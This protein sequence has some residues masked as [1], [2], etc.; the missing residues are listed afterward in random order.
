MLNAFRVARLSWRSKRTF[1]NSRVE[2]SRKDRDQAPYL[3]KGPPQVFDC[4]AS[5]DSV[6]G[7]FRV[8]KLVVSIL[9]CEP[10]EL[11]WV[12][13]GFTSGTPCDVATPPVYTCTESGT[14]RFYIDTNQ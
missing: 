14:D 11:V 5:D 7:R 10:F 9:L 6:A 8:S 1:L 4:V 13:P 3:V 2:Q 12:S